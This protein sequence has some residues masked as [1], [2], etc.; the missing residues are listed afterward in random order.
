MHI[1][2]ILLDTKHR[3]E[4]EKELNMVSGG[5]W[6]LASVVPAADGKVW[7]FFNSK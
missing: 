2:V 6:V 1:K 7:V 5:R 4:M 3:D